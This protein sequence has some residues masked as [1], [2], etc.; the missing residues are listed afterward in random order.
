MA[1][2]IKKSMKNDWDTQEQDLTLAR[3]IIEQHSPDLDNVG[4]LKFVVNTKA[5]SLS[6]ELA[7][8]VSVLTKEFIEKYGLIQGNEITRKVLTRILTAG[9]TVH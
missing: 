8:W 2:T 9:E 6:L 5:R 3:N 7:D 4:L 1:R